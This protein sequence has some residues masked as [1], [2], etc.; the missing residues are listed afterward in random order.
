MELRHRGW[1]SGARRERTAAFLS[2]QGVTL[3][4]VDG[5]PENHEGGR[6]PTIMPAVDL[7]TSPTLAYLRLHGRDAHAYLT[8]KTVAERFKYDY[9]DAEL[10]GV[11]ARVEAL[12]KQADEVYVLFNN[13]H[14]DFAP[15]AAERFR[16]ILGQEVTAPPSLSPPPSKVAAPPARQP[17]PAR[18]RFGR[19]G[20]QALLDL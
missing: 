5:P 8:G 4:G 14:G 11:A 12:T 16:R 18:P 15:K 9:S 7:V 1:L 6:H 2:E 19:G 10:E 20:Q 13:N 3:A 17:K